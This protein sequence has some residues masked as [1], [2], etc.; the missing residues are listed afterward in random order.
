MRG[1]VAV[2]WPS[3]KAG[4]PGAAAMTGGVQPRGRCG[5]GLRCL[6]CGDLFMARRV[7]RR[8]CSPVCAR[9]DR[10]DR[11]AKLERS[12]RA[13]EACGRLFMAGRADKRFCSSRCRVQAHRRR[14]VQDVIEH[15]GVVRAGRA[16]SRSAQR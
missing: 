1:G 5:V 7:D 6:V 8:T 15:C 12:G 16:V 3:A 14:R 10:A 9:R 13:C 2:E 11:A 4:L